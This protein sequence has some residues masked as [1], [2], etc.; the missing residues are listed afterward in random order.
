MYAIRSYYDEFPAGTTASLDNG[1]TL[2]VNGDG[3]YEYTSPAA[4]NNFV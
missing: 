4:R 3:S 2:T 1:M